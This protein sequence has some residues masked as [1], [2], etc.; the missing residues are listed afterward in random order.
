VALCDPGDQLGAQLCAWLCAEEKLEVPGL[1]EQLASCIERL[2]ECVRVYSRATEGR[3]GD[4]MLYCYQ[5]SSD[6]CR[7]LCVHSTRCDVGDYPEDDAH[8]RNCEVDCA[9]NADYDVGARAT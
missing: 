4:T 2:D 8:R 1:G 3:W 9:W 6:D 7:S 5:G